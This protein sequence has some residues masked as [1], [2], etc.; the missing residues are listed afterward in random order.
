M[1]LQYDP[2]KSKSKHLFSGGFVNE[3]SIVNIDKLTPLFAVVE[4]NTKEYWLEKH[5]L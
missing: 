3:C 1:D 5:T 2:L 4:Y